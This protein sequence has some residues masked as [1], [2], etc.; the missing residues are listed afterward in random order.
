MDKERYDFAID[1]KNYLYMPSILPKKNRIVVIG[2][3]HGDY[4]VMI[5]YLKKAKVINDRYEWIGGDTFVVQNG[6][7]V[8]RCRPNIYKCDNPLATY[9]DEAS[10]IKILKFMTE[11]NIKATKFGGGVYSLLGNHELMNVAG[12][13]NYVSYEGLLEF[14]DYINNA[15]DKNDVSDVERGKIGRKY[16][17]A[18]GNEYAKFMGCTRHAAI[19]I[20]SFLFVHGGFVP[21]FYEQMGMSRK[22]SRD[23]LAKINSSVRK[24]LLKLINEQN[25]D[26]IIGSYPNSMFWHRILGEIPPN[27]P[28]DHPLCQKYL[29]PTLKLFNIDGMII[30]HTPQIFKNKSGINGTCDGKLWRVDIGSSHAFSGFV[31]NEEMEKLRKIQ[32]LEILNDKDIRV[33]I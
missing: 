19:I 32:V 24:W 3:I 27:V 1:C 29:E 20:G 2:D 30:G 25:V 10:D 18:P 7:Q 6:D 8:D 28:N 13:L 33:L 4:G 23:D 31:I 16:A 5:N 15:N 9:P 21:E 17:F 11:L 14:K 22:T 12:N 26:K